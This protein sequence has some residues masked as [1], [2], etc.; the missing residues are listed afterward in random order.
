MWDVAINGE[1]PI[2]EKGALNEIQ[3]YYTQYGESSININLCRRKS[4]QGKDLEEIRSIFDQVKSV[5]LHLEVSLPKNPLTPK[6]LEILI[7]ILSDNSGKKIYLYNTTRKK[8]LTLL[9]LT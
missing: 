9:W 8:V 1:E 3:S 6:T 7:K 5:V 4:Y 2:T